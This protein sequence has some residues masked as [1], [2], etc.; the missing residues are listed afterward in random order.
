MKPMLIELE[1]GI[2]YWCRCG[3]SA[4]APFCDG[5][6]ESTTIKPLEFKVKE[7]KKIALCTCGKTKNA[8]VCDGTHAKV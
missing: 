6:H 7:K 8:P 4:N 5:I 3:K 2:Y 1:P